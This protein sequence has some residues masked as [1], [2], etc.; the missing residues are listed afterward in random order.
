MVR[1]RSQL[2]HVTAS[3][4]TYDALMFWCPGCERPG[5]DGQMGGGLHMLPV[6]SIYLSLFPARWGV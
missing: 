3:D 1:M 6:N 4:Q 5:S 2:K